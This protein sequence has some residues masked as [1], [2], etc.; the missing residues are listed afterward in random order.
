MKLSLRGEYALRA[1]LVLGLSYSDQV[2]RIQ[3]I[4]KQQN[5]PKKF[6]EQI[7]NDLK[8]A[9]IAESRRGAADGYPISNR[10]EFG[11]ANSQ[12]RPD[13]L[14]GRRQILGRPRPGRPTAL[15]IPRHGRSDRVTGGQEHRQD[16]FGKWRVGFP[17]ARGTGGPGA[18]RARPDGHLHGWRTR[19]EC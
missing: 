12:S 14:H 17:G 10:R 9:G 3:A 15:S 8:S 5:I 18:F 13:R 16:L 4:S 7:L 2:V 11:P 19:D 6:L 1:L